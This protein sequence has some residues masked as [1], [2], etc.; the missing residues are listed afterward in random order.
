M[1][2]AERSSWEVRWAPAS[3]SS[4]SPARAIPVALPSTRET[5]GSTLGAPSRGGQGPP[6]GVGEGFSEAGGEELNQEAPRGTS[7][8][9]ERMQMAK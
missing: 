8:P 6:W 5:G 3:R 1:A 9:Y 2:L 7:L 4:L